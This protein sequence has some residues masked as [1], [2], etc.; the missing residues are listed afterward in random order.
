MSY[1][2]VE[3]ESGDCMTIDQQIVSIRGSI[4][5]ESEKNVFI[6]TYIPFIISKTAKATNQYIQ[7][8]SDER[9][10]VGLEAFNE[11]IERFDEKKGKF[12]PYAEQVIGSRLKDW[13][14]GE[15]RHFERFEPRE[16]IDIPSEISIEERYLLKEEVFACKK[17]LAAFGIT[18]DDLVQEAPKKEATARKVTDIGRR[19]SDDEGIITKLYKTFKLPM[20]DISDKLIVTKKILKTH[21][22]FIITV[23]VILHEEFQMIGTFLLRPEER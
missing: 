11:A 20:Q 8:L 9:F 18:F 17:K 22:N 5:S 19:A 2:M 14:K 6:K 13:M 15:K 12:L 21:R 4:D 1:F 7:D 16:F 10:I 23:M 3:Q